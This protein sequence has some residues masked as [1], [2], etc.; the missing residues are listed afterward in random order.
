MRSDIAA[1]IR[2]HHLN[3][4]RLALTPFGGIKDSGPGSKEG[5][6]EAIKSF[7]NL[8]TDSMPWL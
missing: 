1:Y 3:S 7:T 2:D 5:V 6:Q 4:M 8:Q